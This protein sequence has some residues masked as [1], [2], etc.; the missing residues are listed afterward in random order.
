MVTGDNIV[1]ARAIATEIGLIKE[2]DDSIAMEGTE[3]NKIVGGIVCKACRTLICPC[4]T[5]TKQAEEK[6]KDIRVDTVANAAEFDRIADKLFVLARSR[7]EDKYCLVTGLKERGNVVAVTGDG[8]NDAPALKKADVG[9][10]MGIA[11]TEVAREAAAIILIDDNFNSIVKAVL[12][13][14]NIY[15]SIRKFLQF[16]L[17]INAVAVTITLVGS[18]LVEKEILNPIQMLWINLIMDSLASLALST[19]NPNEKLLLRKPYTRDANIISKLMKKNIVGQ[20]IF[21]VIIMIIIIFFG[22]LFVPEYEDSLDQDP[23]YI[24]NPSFKWYQG[25]V[26]G[27]VC[28][29][30]FYWINGDPDY[31]TAFKATKNY[32]RHYTFVFNTF[33]MLQ[34]FNFINSRKIHGE[35]YLFL[36]LVQRL[37]GSHGAWIFHGDSLYHLGH[38]GNHRYLLWIWLRT[39]PQRLDYPAMGNIC[40]CEAIQIAIGSTALLMGVVVKFFPYGNEERDDAQVNNAAVNDDVYKKLM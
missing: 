32:S 38:P 20:S 17:T 16:Q 12:W 4:P 39:V 34:L 36:C 11:G 31:E 2:N 40:T 15:D 21:Q 28:S 25:I 33:V 9:F 3:F 22:E 5:T 8:T 10:A 24:A 35:V 30:R 14:R 13:G 23:L 26:G 1:T 37:Q 19:E 7:P 29:G 27:T 6:K 18:S